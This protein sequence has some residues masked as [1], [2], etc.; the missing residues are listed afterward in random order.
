LFLV[1]LVDNILLVFHVLD[2]NFVLD[3]FFSCRLAKLSAYVIAQEAFALLE[4]LLSAL[5][6]AAVW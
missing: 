2:G 6:P 4:A 1:D 3:V 5:L